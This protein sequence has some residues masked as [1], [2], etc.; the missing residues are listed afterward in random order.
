MGN[1]S[2][3]Y[4]TPIRLHTIFEPHW[5]P[6]QSHLSKEVFTAEYNSYFSFSLTCLNIHYALADCY[7]RNHT[8]LHPDRS[9]QTQCLYL[10][11]H[12]L[13]ACWNTA[14]HGAKQHHYIHSVGHR[15][16]LR[17]SGPDPRARGH[18]G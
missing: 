5:S 14:G 6:L 4:S 13:P 12:R 1:I 16:H 3:P 7:S 10:I 15:K 9:F 8:A 2:L 17:L 18:V 11:H